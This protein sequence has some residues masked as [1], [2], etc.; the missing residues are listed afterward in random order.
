[1]EGGRGLPLFPVVVLEAIV[2]RLRELK[3]GEAL[4]EPGRGLG[5]CGVGA[6]YSGGVEVEVVG[7]VG[8]RGAGAG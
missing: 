7:V 1:M 4:M 8:G 6:V 5:D 3:W 2:L